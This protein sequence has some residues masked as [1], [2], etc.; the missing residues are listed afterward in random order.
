LPDL[1]RI[2]TEII[3]NVVKGRIPGIFHVRSFTILFHS[4]CPTRK[5]FDV[6]GVVASF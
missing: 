5:F 3:A 6:D 1:S 2:V 4:F